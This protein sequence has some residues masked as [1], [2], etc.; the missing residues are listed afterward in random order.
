MHTYMSRSLSLSYIPLLP[1]FL[2][3]SNCHRLLIQVPSSLLHLRRQCQ[4]KMLQEA[5][6]VTFLFENTCCLWEYSVDPILGNLMCLPNCLTSY[7]RYTSPSRVLST[8]KA[9][10]CLWWTSLWSSLWLHTLTCLN[11]N[12]PFQP[13]SVAQLGT[14]CLTSFSFPVYYM[15]LNRNPLAQ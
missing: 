13:S 12:Y 6:I 4:N 9:I 7:V 8:L 11:I 3:I 15:T 14:K 2:P 5:F 10:F 1:P